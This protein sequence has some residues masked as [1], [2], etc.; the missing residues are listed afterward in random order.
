M[1]YLPFFFLP[2]N[3]FNELSNQSNESLYKKVLLTIRLLNEEGWHYKQVKVKLFTTY[4]NAWVKL[5]LFN[6]LPLFY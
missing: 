2:I 3:T 6:M 5:T 1:L 4:Q